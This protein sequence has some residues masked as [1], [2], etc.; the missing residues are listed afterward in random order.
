MTYLLALQKAIAQ[1][2]PDDTTKMLGDEY[3]E[4]WTDLEYDISY[5]IQ[6]QSETAAKEHLENWTRVNYVCDVPWDA[7]TQGYVDRVNR[8]NGIIN[9]LLDTPTQS[10]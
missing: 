8:V 2:Q 10:A 5:A 4:G 6:L 3:L 7:N 1:T 9:Y